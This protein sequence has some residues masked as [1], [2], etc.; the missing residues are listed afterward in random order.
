MMQNDTPQIT[1]TTPLHEQVLR[2]MNDTAPGQAFFRWFGKTRGSLQLRRWRRSLQTIPWTPLQRPIAEVTVALVTTGGVHLHADAPFDVQNDASFRRIPRAATAA[3][4]CITHDKY[5]RRDATEDINLVF[6]LQRLRELETEGIIGRVAE[7]HYGFGRPGASPGIGRRGEG[8][9]SALPPLALRSCPGRT[10]QGQ[11]AAHD[12]AG[13]VLAG[14]HCPVSRP[15][16]RASLPVETSDIP[17][18][19][20]LDNRERGVHPGACPGTGD[21]ESASVRPV[22]TEENTKGAY[23]L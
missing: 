17:T 8:T 3:D 14:A 18:S 1:P 20:R 12:S 6:P 13:T 7:L 23:D 2:W 15:G 4:L 16:R 11:P 5:D 10:R 9:A 21:G 22:H 19:C